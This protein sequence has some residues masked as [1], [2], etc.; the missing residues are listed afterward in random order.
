MGRAAFLMKI[1]AGRIAASVCHFHGASIPS[2][3]MIVDATSF[4]FAALGIAVH[5]HFNQ[6]EF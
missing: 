2:Q 3:A 1:P 4:L 5:R 6:R